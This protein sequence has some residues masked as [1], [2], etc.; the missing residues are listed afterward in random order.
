MKLC[1]S[2]ICTRCKLTYNNIFEYVGVIIWPCRCHLCDLKE[3]ETETEIAKC[4]LFFQKRKG[5]PKLFSVI[6]SDFILKLVDH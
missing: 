2:D 6:D 5:Y 1:G 3:K 4:F